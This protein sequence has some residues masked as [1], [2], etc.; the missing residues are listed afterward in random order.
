MIAVGFPQS[1]AHLT[2]DYQLKSEYDH[3]PF[4]PAAS[5]LRSKTAGA[6]KE[7]ILC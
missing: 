1:E 2:L 5:L 3:K 4:A 6:K 7:K